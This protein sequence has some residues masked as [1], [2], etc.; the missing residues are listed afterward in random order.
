MVRFAHNQSK[1]AT[2]ED[3]IAKQDAEISSL[4]EALNASRKRE[5]ALARERKATAAVWSAS[6]PTAVNRQL[7]CS[8][9]DLEVALNKVAQQRQQMQDMSLKIAT[10]TTTMDNQQMQQAAVIASLEQ[11]V[12]QYRLPNSILLHTNRCPQA[13]RTAAR[14]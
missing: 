8:R 14:L 3:T 5:A 9:Q 13:G 11:Q 10:L 7:T 4:T 1:M 6:P 12:L 2:M